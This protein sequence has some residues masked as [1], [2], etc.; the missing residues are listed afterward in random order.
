MST[1]E[2][3]VPESG[4]TPEAEAMESVPMLRRNILSFAGVLFLCVAAIAPAA[5]MLFNVPVMASQA[6]ASVPLAFVLSSVGILLLGVSVIYFARS[7]ASAAGFAT[8]VRAGL[9]KWASFQAGWLMLGAY[10][11]FEGALEATV[12]GGFDSL[13][14]PLGFHMP[15]GWV[16]YAG[17]L[18][19]IVGV[20]GYFALTTSIWVM[21]PFAAL[22]VLALLILDG[23][24]TLKGGAAGHD[25]VHTFLPLGSTVSGVA[26]G[27]FLGIGIAM[28]L[29]ILAFVGFETAGVLGEEAKNPKRTIPRAILTLLLGLTALYIWTAYSATIGVGWQHAG[30]ALGNV[31]NAPQ[32]YVD[33]A[34]RFVGSW[35][36]IALVIFVVT[37]N[38]A[39]AFAMHQAMARYCFDLGR[40][41]IFP[42]GLGRTHPQ[43]GSPFVASIAQTC[44]SLMVL[45]FL[46]LILQ[47]TNAD[48][49]V[50]Y[51]FGFA[52]GAFWQQTSGTVS[53]GWLAS[54]VTMN[55]I[56]VYVLTNVAAFVFAR[57]HHEMRIFSRM[58]APF[59]S[60]VCLLLPLASYIGPAIPGPIGAFFVRLGFASLPFPSNV[61]P[62]F[63]LVW[64]GI[65]VCY[66]VALARRHPDRFEQM[67][68][69]IRSDT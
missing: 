57:K 63:V 46:G 43:W 34:S 26:P 24:I 18:T 17:I 59:V 15:G 37:S 14:S 5:S 1:L 48:G 62:L 47:H 54:L 53:F 10:A 25:L 56:V 19:M 20:L 28:T 64:I 36:G 51:T 68:S 40:S 69:I 38:A 33:L 58:V 3:S 45:G 49:S 9:G 52:N 8:W 6:G 4:G 61:L 32:Q 42:R 41:H 67:G 30:T 39:S 12:G 55:I 13:L 29:G 2:S 65:G 27:G 23:A 50:I 11:L 16:T 35:L 21:A 7:V 60:S 44:F 66:S 31:V 22:E